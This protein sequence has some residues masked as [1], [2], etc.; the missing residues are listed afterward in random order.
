MLKP[1][2]TELIPILQLAVAPVI[3]VSG[4]GLLL[5]TM[6]NKLGRII[7]RSWELTREIRLRPA[8]DHEKIVTQMRGLMKRARI[9][10]QAIAL[11]VLCVLLA[12]VLV[13]LIFLTALFRLD[14]AWLLGLIFVAALGSLVGSLVAFFRDT[15]QT[16]VALKLELG[17][18]LED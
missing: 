1:S 7:D 3:L 6:N 14:D 5:L 17:D 15:Q 13:L 12:A 9:M 10:R 18:W 2:F 16:L 11:A 8:E 4:V